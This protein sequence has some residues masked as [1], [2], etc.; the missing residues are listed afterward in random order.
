MPS[1][2]FSIK[3]LKVKLLAGEQKAAEYLCSK[4]RALGKYTATPPRSS[5]HP[6]SQDKIVQGCLRREAPPGSILG[7]SRF[8]ASAMYFS[9][10]A[11]FSPFL[12]WVWVK[13]KTPEKMKEGVHVSI[14]QGFFL[15]TCFWP[16]AIWGCLFLD[17]DPTKLRLSGP[18]VSLSNQQ[19]RGTQQKD[20]RI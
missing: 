10:R 17:L 6:V 12:I 14:C 7:A 15:G 18:F 1:D 13:I 19:E 9:K 3:P 20:T 2:G 5:R 11:L 8:S 16:T 4:G